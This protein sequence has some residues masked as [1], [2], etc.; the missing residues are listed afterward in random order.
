MH[1]ECICNMTNQS[2]DQGSI[3]FVVHLAWLKMRLNLAVIL[4]GDD[5]G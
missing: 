5:E 3:L 2:G 4:K 1:L